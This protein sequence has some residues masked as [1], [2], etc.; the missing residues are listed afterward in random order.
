MKK[1]KNSNAFKLKDKTGKIYGV[2]YTE[3]KDNVRALGTSLIDL[4]LSN[5]KIVII[6]KNS[7]SWISSYFAS[8]IVGIAVPID[9]ELHPDDVINFLNIS[10]TAIILGDDKN[11]SAIH[12]SISKIDHKIDFVNFDL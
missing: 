1:L 12:E 5:K 2:K 3:F 7:Y 10:E 9:K 8:A 11:L 6:G 4:G